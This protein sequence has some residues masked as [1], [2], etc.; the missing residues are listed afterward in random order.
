MKFTK[1]VTASLV[2]G[3]FVALPAIAR[4]S[5]MLRLAPGS[6]AMRISASF[7][8]IVP[9]TGQ[10]S[11]EDEAK[12]T[13]IARKSLYQI[14]AHECAVITQVFKGNCQM[15]SINVSSYMQDRGNGLRQISVS[16]N[17]SYMVAPD[18]SDQSAQDGKKL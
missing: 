5:S 16:A 9:V 17:A 11:L 2:L 12:A 10:M 3:M 14:A 4:D 13:E 18:N 6:N 7:Q 15:V 8:T 1:L